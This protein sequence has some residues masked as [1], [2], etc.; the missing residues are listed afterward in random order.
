MKLQLQGQ[1]VRLRIDEAEL[2]RL[3][4]GETLVNRTMIGKAAGFSHWLLLGASEAT[5]AAPS[6][7]ARDD[8]WQVELPRQAVVAYAQQLPCRHALGFA[9]DLGGD[10]PIQ[11]D[12]EVDVRDSLKA[13]GPR[14]HPQAAG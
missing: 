2:A 14:R 12:F 7:V 4:A 11:L 10:A 8:G 1:S 9:L 3:L 6:L 5:D 13:R